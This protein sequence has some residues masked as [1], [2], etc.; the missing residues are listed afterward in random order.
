MVEII[1][2]KEECDWIIEYT[3]FLKKKRQNPSIERFVSYEHFTLELNEETKWIYEK[4]NSYLEKVTNTTII[5]EVDTVMINHYVIGDGFEKHQD[6]YFKNQTFNVAVHLNEDYEGGDFVF[7]EPDYV[8]P[9][10]TGLSYIFQN[11]RWHEVKKMTEGN[12]WSMIAFY[13]RENTKAN[14]K[15]I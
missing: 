13:K 10:I 14:N 2:T 12:R 5:K 1:F 11:N 3:K 7:Y 15:I 9:K 8:M 6:L 4:L